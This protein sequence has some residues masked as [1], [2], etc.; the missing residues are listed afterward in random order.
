MHRK[1]INVL[2][3]VSEIMKALKTGVL[4]TTKS[5]E[6]V[7]C[8]TISWGQIGIEWNRMIFT[9]FVRTGRHTHKMLEESGEFSVN[10]PL[11]DKTG[12]IL[13]FCGTKSGA[14]VDKIQ[15]LGLTLIPGFEIN[16]PGIKELP[17]T[18]ECKVIYSQLQEKGRIPDY[19]NR[20][21]YP[22]DV[23]GTFAGSNRDYHTMFF[24]EIVG[25]YIAG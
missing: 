10:I 11:K 15:E 14:D 17:L 7:N 19:V 16:T 18:L 2:D 22:E 9:T 20:A 1:K 5:G 23:P 13:S 25:A 8:M 21:F 3:H 24:G 4:I 6:K 12:K